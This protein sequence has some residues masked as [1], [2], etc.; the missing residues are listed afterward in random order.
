M[1]LFKEGIF[2]RPTSPHARVCTLGPCFG[3]RVLGRSTE[4]S[5]RLYDRDVSYPC[6][7][8]GYESEVFDS[9]IRTSA[10][11]LFSSRTLPRTCCRYWTQGAW[12]VTSVYSIFMAPRY[13]IEPFFFASSANWIP[14]WYQEDLHPEE[15]DRT[16]SARRHVPLD[17]YCL[18]ITV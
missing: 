14:S 13:N 7:G 18:D 8:R 9:S 4:S 11:E 12:P 6:H 3:K 15:G 16:R 5:E 2:D 1:D 17:P 10:P